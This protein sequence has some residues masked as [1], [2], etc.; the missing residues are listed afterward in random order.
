MILAG[1][2]KR[3]C[4]YAESLREAIDRLNDAFVTFTNNLTWERKCRQ[5]FDS[6]C[7]DTNTVIAMIHEQ[8]VIS[9]RTP[10]ACWAR[11]RPPKSMPQKRNSKP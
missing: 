4:K 6:D 10:G 5:T 7:N 2:E 3:H 11:L 9:R 8:G 1:V